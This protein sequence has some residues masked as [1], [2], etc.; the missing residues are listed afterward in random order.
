[1]AYESLS[2]ACGTPRAL[3]GEAYLPLLETCLQFIERYK[4]PNVE[5]AVRHLD[6]VEA[7]FS[8]LASQGQH[9]GGG[10]GSD[11]RGLSG[12]CWRPGAPLVSMAQGQQ[13]SQHGGV[14]RPPGLAPARHLKSG[15][16]PA[17]LPP[18]ADEQLVDQRY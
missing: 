4:Q 14:R 15:A 9:S 18:P 16:P 12:A 5:A 2:V 10:G 3:S 7:L 1:M 13:R 8:W 11:D 17:L 6:L